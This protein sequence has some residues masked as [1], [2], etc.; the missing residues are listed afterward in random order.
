M[1]RKQHSQINK[2][3]LANKNVSMFPIQRVACGWQVTD[4]RNGDMRVFRT[5]HEAELAICSVVRHAMGEHK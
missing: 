1:A 5:R 2:L 3:I 4:G